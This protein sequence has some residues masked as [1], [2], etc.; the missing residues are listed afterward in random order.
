M[1]YDAPSPDGSARTVPH[2]TFIQIDPLTGLPVG[3]GAGG[4]PVSKSGL[5]STTALLT[6]A[7]ATGAG[8]A[9]ANYAAMKTYQARGTTSAGTGAA[10]I[11]VQGSNNGGITWDTIGTI[12]LTLGTVASSDS[13]SSN[14][15]YAQVRGNVTA[16]SGTGASVNMTM[17]Y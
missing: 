3:V 13:F 4:T 10:T 2:A 15:R 17:G 12:T 1:S 5:V 9:V 6:A 7:I 8:A 16:I 14:D 11:Q